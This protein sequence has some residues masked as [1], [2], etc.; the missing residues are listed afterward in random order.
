[1][2]LFMPKPC[3]TGKRKPPKLV[4]ETEGTCPFHRSDASP[5]ELSEF[6]HEL[7]RD[8]R[9]QEALR[10]YGKAIRDN[11]KAAIGWY[12]LATA[13][14]HTDRPHALRYYK[15]ALS[16]EPSAFHYNQ[17]GV[18]LRADERHEDAVRSFK[19]AMSI[20]AANADAAFNLGGTYELLGQYREALRAYRKALDVESANEAR[21][22]N[23]I[24]NVHGKLGDWTA[25]IAAYRE[26]EEADPAFPETHANL[27]HV[28]ISL[29]SFDQAKAQLRRA[30]KALPDDEKLSER[31][32]QLNEAIQ[33]R[34]DEKRKAKWR[35]EIDKRAAHM[36]REERIKRFQQVIGHC[37]PDNKMCMRELLGQTDVDEDVPVRF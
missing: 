25:A 15:H 5:E 32:Q 29:G 18:L 8:G 7:E 34:D 37:G 12:D 4:E 16:L 19:K 14:Q 6:G 28:F 24:G 26:A 21:I 35:Q 20:D 23:N 36:T 17:L 13:L 11:P 1:M 33:K 30:R 10:C 22:Q 27:L 3:L 31:E 2:L 9:R